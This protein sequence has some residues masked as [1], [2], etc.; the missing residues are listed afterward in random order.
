M[1]SNVQNNN[2]LI[3]L[4]LVE[5]VFNEV[6]SYLDCTSITKILMLSN[7]FINNFL[8]IENFQG[9]NY[10]EI[11]DI[12]NII[13]NRCYKLIKE[14]IKLGVKIK[15]KHCVSAIRMKDISMLEF[16][17][18]NNCEIDAFCSMIAYHGCN[19]DDTSIIDWINENNIRRTVGSS[20]ILSIK[21]DLE[22]LEDYI[23]DDFEWDVVSY[24][25]ITAN[26]LVDS[27]Q[28]IKSLYPPLE[29]T[30]Q[31][32]DEVTVNEDMMKKSSFI[33]GSIDKSMIPYQYYDSEILYPDPTK[34]FIRFGDLDRFRDTQDWKNNNI[35]QYIKGAVDYDNFSVVRELLNNCNIDWYHECIFRESIR[36]G[37]LIILNLI[38]KYIVNNQIKPIEYNWLEIDKLKN[39]NRCIVDAIRINKMVSL[40]WLFENRNLLNLDFDENTCSR[41]CGSGNLKMLEWLCNRNVPWSN[42]SCIIA[43]KKG[44]LHILKWLKNNNES[45]FELNTVFEHATKQEIIDWANEVKQNIFVVGGKIILERLPCSIS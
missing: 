20:W 6:C 42:E 37:N 36:S 4:L 7:G 11:L 44:H 22:L 13:E 31:V 23:R 29:Y 15:D 2:K 41:I 3:N 27:I 26:G 10:F 30:E 35:I 9:Y 21:K 38:K 16:L 19:H 32:S 40:K 8:T 24:N 45:L 43:S 12:N 5:N 18:N 1:E 33:L 17:K 25:L 14:L 28:L 34:F 39:V